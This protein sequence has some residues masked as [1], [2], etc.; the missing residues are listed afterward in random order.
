MKPCNRCKGV[1]KITYEAFKK[2]DGT[3]C[4]PWERECSYCRGKGHFP[5]LDIP[6]IVEAITTKTGLRKSRPTGEG[7]EAERAYY[8]WRMARF[9]GG[10][11]TCMPI[12]ASTLGGGDP[13]IDELDIL[14]DKV[15]EKFLGSSLRAAAQWGKALGYL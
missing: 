3:F 1:G 4:D 11:D 10:V 14:A 9:H 7:I 15:A 2:A 13:Y 8:V 5:P 6:A 12:M